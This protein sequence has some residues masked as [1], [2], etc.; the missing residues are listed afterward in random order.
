M[1]LS[2]SQHDT[3]GLVVDFHFLKVFNHF[4]NIELSLT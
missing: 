1:L 3:Y 2:K 4:A